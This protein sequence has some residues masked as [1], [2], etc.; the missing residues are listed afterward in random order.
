MSTNFYAGI[1]IIIG[2]NVT[3][4]REVLNRKPKNKP[5]ISQKYYD[6]VKHLFVIGRK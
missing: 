6:K 5:R 2:G 1:N 4:Q 3:N